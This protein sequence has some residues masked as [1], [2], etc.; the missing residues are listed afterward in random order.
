LTLTSKL[1]DSQKLLN[2]NLVVDNGL[3]KIT[4]TDT[5][6]FLLMTFSRIKNTS[7]STCLVLE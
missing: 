6:K 3:V 7:S 4:I 5:V 1:S 2:K